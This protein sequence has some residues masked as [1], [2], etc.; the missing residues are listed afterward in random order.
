MV[1]NVLPPPD[2]DA[3]TVAKIVEI[4]KTFHQDEIK[5]L[6]VEKTGWILGLVTMIRC[7]IAIQPRSIWA[8]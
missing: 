3:N 1:A 6:F 4:L 5:L 7:S 8:R 2:G